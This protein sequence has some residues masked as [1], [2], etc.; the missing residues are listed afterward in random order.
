LNRY[1]F[2]RL[3]LEVQQYVPLF[4]GRRVI[5]LRVAS[6]MA[7]ANGAGQTVPFYLQ[8]RL[9]GSDD[10]RG[11]RPYRFHDSNRIVANIEYRWETFAGLDMAL[12]LDAG[13]VVPVRSQ[14]NFHDLERTAG[15][16][17][18]FN[19]N[20]SVFLRIDFGFSREGFQFWFKFSNPF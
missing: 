1:S 11:F 2:R 10:L 7:F 19:G 17:F 4:Q 15:F 18:R 9:G 13:K 6:A 3:D 5:A 12:F 8:P 16:G 20:D 14:I